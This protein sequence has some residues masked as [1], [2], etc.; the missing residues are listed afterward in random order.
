MSKDL[1]DIIDTV[2]EETKSQA[3][4]E[5]TIKS[6]NE[7]IN[8]LNSVIDEQKMLIK[9]QSNSTELDGNTIQGEVDIL[10]D[11]IISQRKELTS[12][13]E[14]TE[15]LHDRIDELTLRLEKSNNGTFTTQENDDLIAAQELILAFTEENED[16]KTQIEELRD[17][18]SSAKSET[19]D[20]EIPD[21][22]Q[23]GEIEEL[24]NIK[25]LN[26]QLMEENGLLRVEIESLKVKLQ[27]QIEETSSEEVE[28]ANQKVEALTLELE[29][30]EA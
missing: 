19:I 20:F 13:D 3:E 14:S 26:F 23:L 8:R 17:Q 2:E 4:L 12:K 5:A 10:K 28:L 7:E 27:E 9:D 15:K 24:V 1:K 16:L 21:Q 6:L 22:E 25:R 30:Y 11:L 29:D 18:T